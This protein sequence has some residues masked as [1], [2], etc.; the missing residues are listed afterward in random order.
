LRH[1]I[2]NHAFVT[3]G[4]ETIRVTASFGVSSI[5]SFSD[6]GLWFASVD[7]LLYEAKSSGRNCTRMGS[8][9]VAECA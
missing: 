6:V 2:Q 8:F 4:G 9:D 3:P 7:K 5:D 1:S